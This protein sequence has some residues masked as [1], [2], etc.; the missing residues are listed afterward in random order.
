MSRSEETSYVAIWN[1]RALFTG[2]GKSKVLRWEHGWSVQGTA[3][4]STLLEKR[5]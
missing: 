5:D 1:K 4:R 2:N 3:R